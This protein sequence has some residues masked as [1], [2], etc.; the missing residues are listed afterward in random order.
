M[1]THTGVIRLVRLILRRDRIRLAV[2]VG[3]LALTAI[4]SA[5]AIPPLYPDQ[6]AIDDYARLFGDNPALVAFAGPGY[7][8]DDPNLGVILVNETQLWMMIGAALMSIFLVNRHTRAEEDDERADLVLS[9]VTGRH[10]PVTAAVAVVAGAN[11]ALASLCAVAFVVLG[12]GTVGSFALATSIALAGLTFTAVTAV[13]AQVAS[14][15]RATL[16]LASVVLGAA[17]VIRAVGDI[18]GTWWRWLSP[19]GWAQGI[20]AFADEQWWPLGL[21]LLWC[22]GLLL[23]ARAFFDRRDLGS[24]ILAQRAGPGRAQ[25][26]LT[27]PL[28]LA[29]RLQRASVLAWMAG[30]FVVGVVYGSIGE[31]IEEMVADNP[32]FADVLAQQGG[33]DITASFFATCMSQ[34][35]LLAA[36]FTIASV[37]RP[38]SEETAGRAEQVLALPVSRAAWLRSH[39][40][41]ATSGAALVT[42][43]GGLGVGLSYAVVSGDVDQVGRMLGAALATLPAVLVLGALAVALFGASLRWS[44]FA[45][46]GLAVTVVVQFFGE[47]LGLPDLILAL[48]P[49]RHVPALPAES[50]EALPLLALTFGAM[51]LVGVGTR[52]L[53]ERDISVG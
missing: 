43:S 33:V 7:G 44:L 42:A 52:S 27:S 12:F 47:L 11:V 35:A 13:A 23:L 26:W 37:L 41:V 51:V 10:A 46:A 38:R 14:T 22:A 36:G 32:T 15:G 40:V 4:A 1:S 48:S 2:W 17:F 34:V 5:S 25:A 8:F 24:G 16:G 28:G 49:L 3:A 39:L 18:A 53:R 9:N 6:Q 20:R 50:L 31:D 30:T 29:V 19:L 45:W 21:G